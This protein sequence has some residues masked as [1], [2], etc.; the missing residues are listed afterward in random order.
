MIIISLY[1]TVVST[2]TNISVSNASGVYSLTA[3]TPTLS[4]TGVTGS[5]PSYTINSTATQTLAVTGN[6]IVTSNLGGSATFS[7]AVLSYTGSTNTLKINDGV[8]SN[9]VLLNAYTAGTGISVIGTSP[10]F[11]IT[12]TSVAVTPTISGTGLATVT[13]TVGNNFTV[14]V[15]A[16]GY[17][18]SR[19][20]PAPVRPDAAACRRR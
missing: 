9:T 20:E 5:Y 7:P 14:N 19:P 8:T 15:P 1:P 2:N 18:S 11:V 3:V 4:G 10:N 6:S 16:P 13:P 12:N 17:I